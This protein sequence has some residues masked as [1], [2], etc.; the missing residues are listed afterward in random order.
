[1][2]AKSACLVFVEREYDHPITSQHEWSGVEG[3]NLYTTQIHYTSIGR[4]YTC[5]VTPLTSGDWG[6]VSLERLG[7]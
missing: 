7:G 4:R 2:S 6:L 1:M 5:V 3:D